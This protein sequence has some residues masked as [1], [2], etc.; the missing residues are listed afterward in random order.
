MGSLKSLPAGAD[1]PAVRTSPP[2]INQSI[3][4]ECP[5]GQLGPNRQEAQFSEIIHFLSYAYV[6]TS[7]VCTQWLFLQDLAL[8]L[9]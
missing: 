6:V 8:R 3:Y 2:H 4:I 7:P 9:D 5:G 1:E